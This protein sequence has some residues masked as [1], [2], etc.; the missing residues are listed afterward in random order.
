[1]AALLSGPGHS[2]TV[3]DV[4]GGIEGYLLYAGQTSDIGLYAPIASAFMQA[5]LLG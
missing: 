2:A 3:M 4:M 5:H 1:M